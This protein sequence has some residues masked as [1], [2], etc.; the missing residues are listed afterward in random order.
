MLR[1]AE[2]PGM[3][4]ARR[5]GVWSAPGTFTAMFSQPVGGLSKAD[6]VYCLVNESTD[7]LS[8]RTAGRSGLD[9]FFACVVFLS[10][11]G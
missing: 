6:L 8:E 3:E 4:G 7:V 10:D 1:L 2:M 11:L 9:K 5:E